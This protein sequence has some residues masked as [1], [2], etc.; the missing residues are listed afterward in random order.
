VTDVSI[1][2]PTTGLSSRAETVLVV[3]LAAAAL[4]V[5]AWLALQ[6]GNWGDWQREARPAVEALVGGH[7][8]RFLQLAPAYG[9][10][11]ILRAPF[12]LATKLW[13][14]QDDAIYRASVAP[15]LVAA[16]ALGVWLAKQM[17]ARGNSMLACALALLVCAANPLTVPALTA[18]HPEEL[19]GAVLCTV[20]VLCAVAD[21]PAWA[22]VLLGL[23]VANKEW[24]VLAVGPVLVALPHARL[25]ALV[26]AA[27]VAAI[28]QAPLVL[29]GGLVGQAT[30]VGLNSGTIFQPW[31]IWWWLGSG[32]GGHGYR[33]PPVWLGSF[34][35]TLPV[36]L[37]PV[38]TALYAWRW[39]RPTRRR[40]DVL[41]LLALLM[42]LRCILDPWDISYYAL[43]FLIAL[44]TWEGL[45]AQRPPV[46]TLAATGA[47]WFIL[48]G[49]SSYGLTPD[50]EALVFT[51]ISV[52]SLLALAVA[53]Y[54]PGLWPLI[55]RRAGS[56]RPPPGA[57]AAA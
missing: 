8:L 35:H 37:M 12:V 57:E 28:V 55:A 32:G 56:L 50:L 23:A 6:P 39:R 17:R 43:P 9:G 38:L 4:L 47:A 36:A 27:A 10:S 48:R 2:M 24:A 49:T 30:A 26:I 14:G 13:H 18:G 21:R 1:W 3:A 44:V 34:G 33:L 11:L 22:G 42:G 31:Q 20:A 51:I 41:L 5:V 40:H 46:L 25:R 45:T 16:G 15:C 29:A 52:P 54:A 19:L 7:V 53:V